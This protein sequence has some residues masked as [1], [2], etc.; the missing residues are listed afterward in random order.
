MTASRHTDRS[1]DDLVRWLRT[2]GPG[3]RRASSA[4]PANGRS[5][6]D[7]AHAPSTQTAIEK[8]AP[9]HDPRRCATVGRAR[10]PPSAINRHSA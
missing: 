7:I 9:G 4:E 6:Q 2:G 10:T 1:T 8:L 3:A 5:F